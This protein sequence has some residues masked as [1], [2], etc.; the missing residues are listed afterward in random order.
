MLYY[1]NMTNKNDLIKLLVDM[2]NDI[3]NTFPEIKDDLDINLKNILNDIDTNN[4]IDNLI[5]YFKTVYPERFFDII[6]ENEE[7]FSINSEKNV[8]FLPGIDFK[9]LWNDNISDNTKN[10]LWKYL[11]LILFSTVSDIDNK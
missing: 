2:L 3:V 5:E 8:H 1:N 11:Q 9:E 6:Y 4:S 7:I 10:T